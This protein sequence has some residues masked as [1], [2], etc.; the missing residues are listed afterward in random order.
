M[1][2]NLLCILV[3]LLS[4]SACKKSKTT[5][6]T[7]TNNINNAAIA[8]NWTLTNM[9]QTNG[10]YKENGVQIGTYTTT[11]SNHVGGFLLNADGTFT[12]NVGYDYEISSIFPPD[13]SVWVDTD[14]VPSVSTAGTFTYNTSTK[15]L[16][17]KV[18]AQTVEYTVQSLASHNLEL[19]IYTSFSDNSSGVLEESMNTTHLYFTK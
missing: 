3:C 18:G 8:G 13:P 9:T 14:N 10:V 7:P 6:T 17:F 16:A 11:S 2:N 4:F 12:S 19:T 5:T 1:K 15:K